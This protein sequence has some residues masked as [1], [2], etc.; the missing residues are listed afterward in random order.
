MAITLNA[1]VDVL[2]RALFDEREKEA[3]KIVKSALVPLGLRAL[4]AAAEASTRSHHC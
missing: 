2:D 4:P 3:W 1:A